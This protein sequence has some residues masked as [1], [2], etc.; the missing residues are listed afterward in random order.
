MVDSGL[1]IAIDPLFPPSNLS[2]RMNTNIPLTQWELVFD[3]DY[4]GKE[5]DE[6]FEKYDQQRGI[7]R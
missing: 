7:T 6:I 3:E 2:K 1:R 5:L 4:D